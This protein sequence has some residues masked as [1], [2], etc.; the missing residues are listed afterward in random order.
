MFH[1]M[2][3]N[4]YRLLAFFVLSACGGSLIDGERLDHEDEGASADTG[5]SMSGEYGV[6]E[7]A[8]TASQ[9]TWPA[10]ALGENSNTVV[11]LQYLLRHANQTLLVDGSFGAGTLAALQS[12]QRVNALTV[13]SSVNVATWSK[14]IVTLQSGSENN[15]VRAAQHLLKTQHGANLAVTGLVGPTTLSAIQTFQRSKCLDA[16]GVVGFFTWNALLAN[17]SHCGSNGAAQRI[18]DAHNQQRMTLW[19]RTFS[20]FDGADPLN[21]IK[22]AAAGRKAKQSCHGTAPCGSVNVQP[23]LLNA[24]DLLVNQK[25][26]RVFVT[27]IVGGSHSAN[28]FHYAGRAIDIDE[29]NG[30]KILGSS[31]VARDF[32][33]QCRA[34]GA[35][36][37]LGPDNDPAGHNDHIHCAF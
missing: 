34:L 21:N 37:A 5:R 10:T 12:F 28:S 2:R 29:V 1:R 19:D 31:A 26:Y 24:V 3:A 20:R 15:A 11:A 32:V 16:D 7:L 27:T 9:V 25:G 4:T 35:I 22:D 18:L 13:T 30:V 17:T 36:E 6:E 33:A 8:L 14:L 23:G